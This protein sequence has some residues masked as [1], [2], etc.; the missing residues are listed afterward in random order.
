MSVFRADLVHMLEW[1]VV[2]VNMTARFP[3]LPVS[4][5][6]YL[7]LQLQV[8]T[9]CRFALSNVNIG[10]L[11][12]PVRDESSSNYFVSPCSLRFT[13]ETWY[14]RKRVTHTAH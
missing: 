1:A 14:S 11:V 10:D 9:L 13:N 12:G 4:P 7:V 8:A 6:T 2:V 5:M 3:H